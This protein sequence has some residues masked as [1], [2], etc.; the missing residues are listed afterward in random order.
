MPRSSVWPV[1]DF[2]R[3]HDIPI[4]NLAADQLFWEDLDYLPE[5]NVDEGN[6][7]FPSRELDGEKKRERKRYYRPFYIPNSPDF[8]EHL[9]DMY[10]E[11]KEM[12]YNKA[13]RSALQSV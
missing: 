12:D 2:L 10:F 8:K 4:G 9:S 5:K 1:A 7:L 6:G 13:E 11:G 3:S